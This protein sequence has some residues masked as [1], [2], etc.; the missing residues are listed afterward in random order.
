MAKIIE[1]DKNFKVIQFS[2]V[3]MMRLTG[4]V[5]PVCDRCLDRKVSKGYYIAVLNQ[6]FCPKCYKKWLKRAVKH[7]EDERV[8]TENFEYYNHLAKKMTMY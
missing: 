3:E 1:N 6:W 7:P 8:E 2:Y 4:N 5:C